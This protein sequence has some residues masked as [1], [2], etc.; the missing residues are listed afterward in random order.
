MGFDLM[1]NGYLAK[2]ATE[3]IAI[4]VAVNPP[5]LDLAELHLQ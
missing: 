5:V 2:Y 1:S 3:V 4:G